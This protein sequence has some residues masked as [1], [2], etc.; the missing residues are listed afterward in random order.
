MVAG[1][2]MVGAGDAAGAGAGGMRVAAGVG[3]MEGT[4]ESSRGMVSMGTRGEEGGAVVAGEG[5]GAPLVGGTEVEGMEGGEG[6]PAGT[7]A[8]VGGTARLRQGGLPL[9]SSSLGRGCCRTTCQ[10][11]HQQQYP[12]SRCT[13]SSRHLLWCSSHRWW[14]TGVLHQ[15][16]MVAC[17]RSSGRQ[18][19]SC[20]L[21][22]AGTL[23]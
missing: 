14:C 6:L 18:H 17:S 4:G 20:L 16:G 22:L 21:R 10:H 12:S 23:Q 13:I 7:V 9:S 1:G 11:L 2:V 3:A 19:P 8:G 15:G 5:V